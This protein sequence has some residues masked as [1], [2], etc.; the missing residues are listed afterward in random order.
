MN[1]NP[2]TEALA[3][4]M[5]W[6][7]LVLETRNAINSSEN[8]EVSDIRAVEIISHHKD[9]LAHQLIEKNAPTFE[10][11]LLLMLALA[12]HLQPDLLDYFKSAEMHSLFGCRSGKA[13]RGL[14]PTG[15]TF[16]FILAGKNRKEHLNAQLL[17]S[18]EIPL[19]KN[20]ILSLTQQES[21]EPR[22]SGMLTVAPDFIE[23]LIFEKKQAPE[24]STE[25]P[26]MRITTEQEWRDMILAPYTESL[27]D[28]LK[29]WLLYG[30]SLR[31]EYGFEKKMRKGFRA[32]FHGP[33]GTGKTLAV[34]L[35]GKEVGR[36][37]YRIDLSKLVSKYIGETEKNLGRVFDRAENSDWILFFDE[38]DALFG[39]RTAVASSNDRYA[40]QEINYLLQRV[41]EFNGIV[42]LASNMKSNVDNAFLRRFE[43]IVLFPYPEEKERLRLWKKAF[44]EQFSFD[45][46]ADLISIANKHKL[47][48]ANIS[49][50][51]AQTCLLTIAEKSTVITGEKLKHCIRRELDKENRTS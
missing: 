1:H 16:C 38:A 27:L 4:E 29:K 8:A 48:G 11:R 36:D 24:F 25:F 50:I 12:P 34:T 10:E 43:S 17:F 40:N 45:F 26:A 30:E 20:K 28:E 15:E 41:D 13:H 7:Q 2:N 5:Q 49:N 33:P 22:L 18:Q 44:P 46:S 31:R 14:L 42:I 39:K 37:V 32:F 6:L 23:Q 47:T 51:A 21:E 9:S 3:R 35:L 19:F